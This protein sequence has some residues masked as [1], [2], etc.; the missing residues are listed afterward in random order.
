MSSYQERVRPIIELCPRC[1]SHK[2]ESVINAQP[3]G[4]NDW[5]MTCSDFSICPWADDVQGVFVN[6]EFRCIDEEGRQFRY[7]PRG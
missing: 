3:N 5:R 2:K 4:G 6:G 7:F 1:L